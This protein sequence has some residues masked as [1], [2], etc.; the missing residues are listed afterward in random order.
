MRLCLICDKK[1]DG[2]W[3]R[4][5]HRF[6]KSYELSNRV[7]FN[8]RHN[9]ENDEGCTYHTDTATN[10]T[11]SGGK[12]KGRLALLIIV[13]YV[14]FSFF[15][16]VIPIIIKAMD[17][18]SEG[19]REI[20]ETEAPTSE[21][22]VQMIPEY[23]KELDLSYAERMAVMETLLPVTEEA[24]EGYVFRYYRPETITGLGFSCDEL[25]FDR[26]LREFE[27]WLEAHWTGDYE[28]DEKFSEYYNYFY[29]DEEYTWLYFASFRDY[30]SSDDFAV[31]AGYDTAT[32][33]LHMI[34]FVALTEQDIS[35]LYYALLTELDPKTTWTEADFSEALE[36]ALKEAL[37]GEEYATFYTSDV[38]EIDVQLKDGCYSVTFYPAYP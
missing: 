32:G 38:L 36:T 21:S 12:K 22:P 6:V 25:H 19:F 35:P 1:I 17:S 27:K 18:F 9:P 31:R 5:C 34:G 20:Y 4:N 33:R 28:T 10:K 2:S 37:K 29:E 26:T 13:L 16:V 8:E 3:C 30:Y 23:E 7:Y 24:E 15:G 11:E 14:A